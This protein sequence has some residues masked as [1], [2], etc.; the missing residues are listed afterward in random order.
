M[1]TLTA[2]NLANGGEP[3]GY[4]IVMNRDE[5]RTRSRSTP[6]E[7]R[8]TGD[9]RA[10]WP[11][12][13][14]SGGTWIGAA[15]TGLTLALVNSFLEPMPELP[16]DIV[17]RGT[18]IPALINSQGVEE[19]VDRLSV[20]QIE[21]FAPFRLLAID[22]VG[23]EAGTIWPRMVLMD[24]NR[25]ELAVETHL[26]GP[27][28]LVS[29]GLGDS[30]VAPRIELFEEMLVSKGLT[31]ENQDAFHAHGWDDRREISVMLSRELAWTESVTVVECRLSDDE[32]VQ[33]TYRSIEP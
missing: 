18:I 33:M 3:G 4:R 25:Y 26:D 15:E 17:S 2:I 6:P 14:D 28:C 31:P 13:P 16:A 11:V 32:A 22:L 19:V 20:M 5:L 10:I 21:R 27:V 7:W 8:S 30:K 1:C 12:D 24:W 9:V 23:D 29:S